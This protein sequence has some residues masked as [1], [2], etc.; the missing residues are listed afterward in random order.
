MWGNMFIGREKELAE[1][2]S[3]YNE[4]K[5]HLFVLYG[6]TRVSVNA[7]GEMKKWEFLF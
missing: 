5:F 3:M 1:L 6:H 2:N 7:N 4:D